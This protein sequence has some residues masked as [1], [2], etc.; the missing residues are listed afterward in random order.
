M[1]IAEA[2]IRFRTVTF[3]LTALVLVLGAKS[4]FDLPRLEDPEFTIKDALVITA[5]P[6]ATA[7]E[8]ADEV[9]D[10]IERAAQQ[11]GQVERVVSRSERGRSTVTVTIRDQ[12]GRDQLP[13]VWDE[14]RRKIGDA[15]RELPPGA[16]PSLVVDDFGDVFGIFYAITGPDYSMAEL[17]EVAKMF[18]RELLAVQDVKK[19]EIFAR[20]QEAIF[21]EISREQSARLGVSPEQVHGV[22]REQN[23]VAPSGSVDAGA[24]RFALQPTGEITDVAA[25]G[26]LI[27]RHGGESGELVRLRDIATI[28]RAYVDPPTTIL[29]YDGEPAVGLGISTVSGGNVVTLGADVER[30]VAALASR[31]PLGVELHK[32]SF[33][34]DTVTESINDFV[35]NLA[36]SVVIVIVVLL[37]AMGLRSGLIIGAILM[38]SI[39]GTFLVM[40]ASGLILERISLGALII[41]LVMLVDN[42][43]VITEGM[44]IAIQRGVDR[45]KAAKDIV[46]QTAVPLLGSTLIA[47]LAFGAI[48]LS[49]DSTGEYCRSLFDVLLISLMISWVTAITVTPLFCF[50]FLKAPPAGSG[51]PKDPYAG[52][53]YR[54]YKSVLVQCMRHGGL[55]VAAMIALLAAA[56]FGFRFVE[57]SFFPNSTRGQFLVDA[58]SPAGTRLDATAARATEI[59]SYLLGVPGVKNVTTCVG[60]G[61]LRFLLTYAP[62]RFDP[63]FAQFIIDVDDHR[64]IARILPEVQSHLSETFPDVLVIG[65]RF[66]LGP[67]EGG[68]I[69]IRFSGP[70]TAVLRQLSDEAMGILRADGGA[71][72]VRI[73]AREEVPVV[74]PIFAEAPARQVGITRTDLGA[75]LQAFFEGRRI[76]VF[77]E[78]DELIPIIAR[79]PEAERRD[80]AAVQD[81]QIFSPVVGAG[82]PIRQIVSGFSTELEEPIVM[83]RDRHPTITV[84]ADQ[85]SGLASALFERI[86]PQIEAIPLPEGYRM[87]WGGEHEDSTNAQAALAGTLPV[88]VLMMV[89]IVVCLFNSIRATLIIWLTVPLSIVGVVVGLLVFDKPFGF[90]ALLGALSLSGMLIKNGIVLIDEINAQLKAGLV[91][92]DAVVQAAV[93]RVRPVL[94]AVLTTVL[95]LVPLIPDVFFG[96]MAVTIVVGLLFASVLTLIVVPVLYVLFFGYRPPAA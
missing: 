16:G 56:V 54:A 70:D 69:Q 28:R 55:T 91:P 48:G 47:V 39:A 13:Q 36:T 60:Q 95:G 10:V 50:V 63:A 23:L 37:C 5:Y 29:R 46:R 62:E 67:G 76:G 44:L 3:V 11:L 6:G 84:H 4:Y 72:G 24:M 31:I 9:S 40:H 68:R 96:A 49:D 73:D 15:Q 20:Q 53:I 81:V 71:K 57:N 33:Q 2:S 30:R 26:D 51:E 64:N 80:P 93:S 34:A 22:L 38:V 59:E 75:A 1:N 27:I 90:M 32:I 94:M 25:L 52:K 35:M 86:R 77:R 12:Y 89:V 74:R 17:N 41:A 21:V 78:G 82:I 87:E 65:R 14:L 79:A 58:W 83:R 19:V 88:F 8:V 92:W 42:A 18:R 66:L 61:T 7:Q 85:S 43:I 45:M